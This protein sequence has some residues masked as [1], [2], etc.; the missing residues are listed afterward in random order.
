[1]VVAAQASVEKPPIDLEMA[2]MFFQQAKKA[3][4]AGDAKGFEAARAVMLIN[5]GLSTGR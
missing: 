4:E 5:L 2:E 1:M 3:H